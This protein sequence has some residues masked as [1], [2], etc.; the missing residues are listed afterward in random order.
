[1]IAEDSLEG[2]AIMIL[3]DKNQK[4]IKSVSLFR[5]GK[6]YAV[7]TKFLA[8][9]E[10]D[11]EIQVI[12]NNKLVAKNETKIFLAPV[13]T[14]K[15]PI[16]MYGVMGGSSEYKKNVVLK[17][18]KEHLGECG[19]ISGKRGTINDLALRYG[20]RIM[21]VSNAYYR[22]LPS[23]EANPEL[24]M[25]VSTG[26][27]PSYHYKGINGAPLC[28][29]NAINR[30]KIGKFLAKEIKE[31]YKYPAFMDIM[32][33][34]DDVAMYGDPGEHLLA[35]Y[36]DNCKRKFKKLTGF[37]APLAPSEK[38][39][40]NKGVVKDNDPWYLW[41]KFR[42][43]NVY[44]GWNKAME[45]AKDTVDP[46]IKLMPAIGGWDVFSP[47][48][49]LN[50]PDTYRDIDIISF[51]HY[52]QL[53]RPCIYFMSQAALGVMGNRNKDYWCIPQA[54]D[55]AHV[56]KDPTAHTML[57]R[58]EFYYLI[59]AGAKGMGYFHYPP[60]P[61]L[62]AWEEF[63]NLSRFGTRFG[64]FLL[65]W[66]KQRPETAILTSYCN[67]SYQWA[68]GG[69]HSK[70][71]EKLYISLLKDH[72]STDMIADEEILA[73][74]LDKYKTLLLVDIDYLTE[75]IYGK[76]EEFIKNGGT[77]FC[78]SDCF[79]KF[80][81][82][83]ISETSS[84]SSE[85]KKINGNMVDIDTPDLIFSEFKS[86]GARYLM[87]VNGRT[88]KAVAGK[89]TLKGIGKSAIY[90]LSEGRLLSSGGN[91]AE[92]EVKLEAAG[93]KLIGIYPAEIKNISILSPKKMFRG[94]EYEIKV[95]I[96]DE[97][98]KIIKGL[99]P[100]KATV[101]NPAGERSEYSDF[102][103]AKN[104]ALN[105]S[106]APAVNDLAG[107]W[108]LEVSELSSGVSGKTSFILE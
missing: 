27:W 40:K 23:R 21:P 106:F 91:C 99:F 44:A 3:K 76:I 58:N 48:W 102:Y 4:V 31:F 9:G 64:Q 77:V 53:S 14:P 24:H 78:D 65:N 96:R 92:F 33:F 19:I 26:K 69:S 12:N 85:L 72:V 6:P 5:D 93:G 107:E 55:Y 29:G 56:I 101:K 108:E 2:K 90:D 88:D 75:S 105:F 60:M 94:K 1:M 80:S 25:R 7:D 71:S 83:K 8:P 84:W 32:L 73:G 34:D 70:E 74:D 59:A 61:G 95:E 18:L 66:K 13:K 47:Q 43:G 36:C 98:S 30:K 54:S 37:D 39:L 42:T 45:E 46:K 81:G 20:L 38:V 41:M 17:D 35:C 87:L 89:T 16:G 50:P 15:F 22:N 86:G 51:Y 103:A 63:K 104:G 49:C 97:N 68:A 62:K 82:S 52:P 10:Y 100:L 67:A 28:F 11:I 57:V 79:L